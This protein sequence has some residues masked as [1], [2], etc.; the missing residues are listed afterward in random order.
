MP[1]PRSRSFRRIRVKTPAK[2]IVI[3]YVRR[4]GKLSLTCKNC[5]A[6]LP[7]TTTAKTAKSKKNPTRPYAGILCSKCMRAKIVNMVR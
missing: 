7:G 4:K 5:S 2:R 6:K 1:K 3:H